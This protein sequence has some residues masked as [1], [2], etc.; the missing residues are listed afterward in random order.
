MFTNIIV[1]YLISEKDLEEVVEL[2]KVLSPLNSLDLLDLLKSQDVRANKLV[3]LNLDELKI[4]GVPSLRA[5]QF[6]NDIERK[7]SLQ[8]MLSK[9]GIIDIKTFKILLKGGFTSEDVLKLDTDALKKL[10]LVY[11]SEWI[12]KCIQGAKIQGK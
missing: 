4:Y 11:E 6:Q 2:Q 9:I 3:D 8:Q 12:L 7:K 10:G 5:E 1:F